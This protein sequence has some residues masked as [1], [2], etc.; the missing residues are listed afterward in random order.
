MSVFG[1]K[2]TC[3]ACRD[4]VADACHI[5][6]RDHS[7]RGQAIIGEARVIDG[8]TIEI[9]EE[10]G[11]WSGEFVFPWDWRRGKRLAK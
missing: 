1:Y 4:H 2:R 8:D 5:H 10:H 9:A 11:I 6:Q 3:R 7:I